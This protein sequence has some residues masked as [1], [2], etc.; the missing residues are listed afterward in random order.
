[1]NIR[2]LGVNGR[3]RVRKY[4]CLSPTRVASDEVVCNH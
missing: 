1:M 3:P 4:V 2:V